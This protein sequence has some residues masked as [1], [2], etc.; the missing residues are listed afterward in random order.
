MA[1]RRSNINLKKGVYTAYDDANG[2]LSVSA[3]WGNTNLKEGKAPAP[4]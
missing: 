3:N 4:R 2:N 1:M